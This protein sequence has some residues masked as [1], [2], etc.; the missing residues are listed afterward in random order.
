MVQLNFMIFKILILLIQ[1][2]VW[3]LDKDFSKWTI[4]VSIKDKF[5]KI[6]DCKQNN[7]NLLIALK[8]QSP[9]LK[10]EIWFDFFE[11]QHIF[12]NLKISRVLW[13]SF[14]TFKWGIHT[15]YIE[16]ICHM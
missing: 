14:I 12:Q 13:K 10:Y 3:V 6:D 8:K 2:E 4:V 11:I 16:K 15:W 9:Y 7:K 1:L 5:Y